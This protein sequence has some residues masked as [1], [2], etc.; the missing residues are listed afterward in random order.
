LGK[1][2]WEVEQQ[3]TP[4]E[5]AEWAAYFTLQRK[6]EEEAYRKMERK[7]RPRKPRHLRGK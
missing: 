3:I 1:F 5:V 4:K 2:V 6:A 7:N